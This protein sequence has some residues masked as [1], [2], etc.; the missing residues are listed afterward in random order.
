MAHPCHGCI[1]FVPV[2][3][4]LGTRAIKDENRVCDY[5]GYTGRKRPCPFGAG[6]TIKQTSGQR[7]RKQPY[8]KYD[9]GA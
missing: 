7:P 4:H 6:C 5:I 1:Y 2:S 8:H 9:V 3:E